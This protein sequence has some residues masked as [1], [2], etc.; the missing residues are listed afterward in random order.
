MNLT[1]EEQIDEICEQPPPGY[2]GGR[3][4]TE[5]ALDVIRYRTKTGEHK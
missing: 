1:L 5:V 3:Q 4:I 2:L